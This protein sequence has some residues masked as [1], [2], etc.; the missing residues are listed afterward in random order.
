MPSATSKIVLVHLRVYRGPVCKI[1]PIGR[2]ELY[3]Q[4][5]K[6]HLCFVFV[7]CSGAGVCH[8]A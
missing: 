3:R 7:L 4:E 2:S 8:G 1:L 5:T 6:V